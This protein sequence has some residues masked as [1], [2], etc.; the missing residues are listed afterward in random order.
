MSSATSP[1][2]SWIYEGIWG[3]LTSLFC[4]PRD[5]PELP[6]HTKAS[7]VTRK[8][9]PGFVRYLKFQF[10]IV[11]MILLV[12]LG[13][14]SVIALIASESAWVLLGS[15]VLLTPI[16]VIGAINYLAIYLRF[17]TTWYVFS[18]RSMRLRRGIWFIR[19]STITFE[20]VQNVKVTQG[21]LQRYFGI[22]NVVVETAGG[23]SNPNNPHAGAAMHAGLIE[24]VAEASEI[25]D[26]IMSHVRLGHTS[27]LGDEAE[28]RATTG[29][30]SNQLSVLREIRD[31]AKTVAARQNP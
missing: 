25:R 4:V 24:G 28:T 13:I 30:S 10:W 5:P 26:S 21:P 11:M 31:L 8:P 18:D 22:A 20:N 19:E 12:V 6:L 9:S 2:T 15:I 3:M 7:V 14:G 1:R 16:V 23:G 27:G 17:D 29:M